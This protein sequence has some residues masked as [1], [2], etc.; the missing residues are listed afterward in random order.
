MDKEKLTASKIAKMIDH[1]LLK[2]EMTREE[3]KTGCL[4]ALNYD[5]ASVVCETK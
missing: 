5:T 2:P 4:V 3:V 1:A